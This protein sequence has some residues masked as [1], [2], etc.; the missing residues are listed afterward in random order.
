M[1]NQNEMVIEYTTSHPSIP[2]VEQRQGVFKIG[3]NND[4]PCGSGKKYKKCCIGTIDRDELTRPFNIEPEKV[5][6]M[7]EEN[8][9]ILMDELENN[10]HGKEYVQERSSIT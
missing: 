2:K 4:C 8:L 10:T 7:P 1:N 6:T 9:N 3:R 5:M